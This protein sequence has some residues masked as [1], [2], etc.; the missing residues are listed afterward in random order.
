MT[1]P[2]P[3][4]RPGQRGPEVVALQ[5]ALSSVGYLVAPDGSYGP[6]TS[7]AV[8]ALQRSQA[9]AQDGV[10]GPRTADALRR[11]T[12]AP[13]TPQ[14][15]PKI[16]GGLWVDT[17]PK[18]MP[19][20]QR[21][22]L[23]WDTWARALLATGCTDFSIAA[24]GGPSALYDSAFWDGRTFALAVQALKHHGGAGI[25]VGALVWLE[26]K[27]YRQAARIWAREW[28]D[29]QAQG[30]GLDYIELDAEGGWGTATRQQ[31]EEL[32]SMLDMTLRMTAIPHNG[33]SLKP[34]E[35]HLLRAI[36]DAQG[37]VAFAPQVY[38]A[39]IASKE[40]THAEAFRPGRFQ[41]LCAAHYIPALLQAHPQARIHYGTALYGQDHPAPWPSGVVALQTALDAALSDVVLWHPEDTPAPFRFWS[42][43][44]I[45]TDAL[46]WLRRILAAR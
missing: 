38:T 3:T 13:P 33:R 30:Y 14:A 36:T 24:F 32:V 31:A 45:G 19:G 28:A 37:E 2:A 43:K 8:R 39:Y 15:P 17:L 26:S 23:D 10:Y 22:I 29:A 41:D 1:A 21:G 34:S 44:A 11:L 27:T 35:S 9:L 7:E 25:Q 46:A 12:S 18:Q 4:L 16:T 40:W 20:A 5:Q 6:R 42:S